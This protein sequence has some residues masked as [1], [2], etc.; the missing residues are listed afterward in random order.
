MSLRKKYFYLLTKFIPKGTFSVLNNKIS[1]E[2][3]SN[4]E[5]EKPTNHL[6]HDERKVLWIKINKTL[7]IIH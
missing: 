4:S 3:G 7:Q 2:L 1:L 5:F 6:S